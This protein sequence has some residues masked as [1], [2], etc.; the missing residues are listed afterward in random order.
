MTVVAEGHAGY[1]EY[2]KDIVCAGVSALM[3]AYLGCI[4]EIK[5]K[6]MLSFVDTEISDGRVKIAVS[7]FQ[8]EFARD[9]VYQYAFFLAKGMTLLSRQF[10][11]FVLI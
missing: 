2:G 8:C 4:R 10:P 5:E 11:E 6:N 3:M 9:A 1:G 7:G